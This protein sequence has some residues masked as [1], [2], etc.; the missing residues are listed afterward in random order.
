MAALVAML[1]LTSLFVAPVAAAN[2]TIQVNI[3]GDATD[4][5]PGDGVCETAAGNGVCTLRAA[6][7]EAN[8]RA[9]ADTIQLSASTYTLKI[10]ALLSEADAAIGDLNVWEDL[11]I[12]GKGLGATTIQASET[13]WQDATSRVFATSGSDPVA[14]HLASMT[15]RNGNSGAQQGGGIALTHT[16]H[17]LFLDHVVM[18]D[19]HTPSNSGGAIAGGGAITIAHSWIRTNVAQ[20]AGAIETGGTLTISDSKFDANEAVGN[21]AAIRMG[22]QAVGSI[23][24]SEFI[25][26]IAGPNGQSIIQV[27]RGGPTETTKLTITNST[28]AENKGGYT[29]ATAGVGVEG[30]LKNDTFAG[31]SGISVLG[32]FSLR[33]TIVADSG[34]T[35]CGGNVTSLG[36]NLFDDTSCPTQASDLQAEPKLGQW[37]MDFTMARPPMAG[38]PAIDAG[39]NCPTIDQHGTARPKDGDSDGLATCDIGAI[40]APKGTTP[41]PPPPATTFVPID[42]LRLLDTRIGNGLSGP[43]TAN[44]A[45]SVAIAGRFWIPDNAVAITANLTVVGQQQAGY[46]SVTPDPN[47]NPSTSALN[48]PLGDIRPNNITS[49]LAA[50]GKLSIVYRAGA[51]KKTHVVLDVTGYFVEATTGATYKAVTPARL[52]DTRVGNGLSGKF[53]ARTVR[54]FDVAGRGGVPAN[55]VAVTGNLTV[56]GQNAAGYVTLGPDLSNAPLTSTI[57]FPLGETRAN[58]VTV[59]LLADGTLDAV[60]I[61]PLGKTTHLLFDVTGYYV[62][63]STGSKYY[64]LDP[65]RVLDT[66]VGKGLTGS[67]KTDIA[68]SLAVEGHAGVP[69]AATAV[70]GNLT[71]VGQM[72]DGY[73]SMTKALDST[74]DTSTLNFPIGDVRANGVTGPLTNAGTVGLVYKASPGKTTDL[75]LDITGYFAP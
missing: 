30:V 24:R 5:N 52:L 53:N 72:D 37:V 66:R 2:P 34:G 31:N 13:S 44:T 19:N 20:Q 40:E 12:V 3:S 70:T 71:V 32:N 58:G 28:F 35:N 16:T 11:T 33:N 36:H 75:I 22:G 56:V 54:D 69:T 73:V 61:A 51:G 68:R 47:N 18:Q 63:D 7:M 41:P 6:V 4:A 10:P 8:E 17:K 45:R 60:Y 62:P 14:L 15:V 49:P 50:D 57:N 39:A 55:A 26:N 9:G 74:P 43:F 59:Q 25:G 1:L 64:P 23:T 67:F 42:S 46:L 38:S 48:F 29:L 65:G 27:G 21:A